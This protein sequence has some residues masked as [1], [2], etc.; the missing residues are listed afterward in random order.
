[1]LKLSYPLLQKNY[2][3][4]TDF[5]Q[6]NLQR[7]FQNQELKFNFSKNKY[8]FNFN[9]FKQDLRFLQTNLYESLI[10]Y[11]EC[12]EILL[13]SLL[14][15]RNME[16][17]K[18]G[19]SWLKE[20]YLCDKQSAL[21]IAIR[22]AQEYFNACSSYFDSDM[23]FARECLNL[24]Q[25]MMIENSSEDD[26]IKTDLFEALKY[27]YDL[28]NAIRLICDEFDFNILPVQV[29]VG[30]EQQRMQI[31]KDIIIKKENSYKNYAKLIELGDYLHIKDKNQIL[32][33]VTHNSLERN[34]LLILK[35]M[36]T[37]MIKSNY[38]QAWKCV[39]KLS[40]NL[41]QSLFEHHKIYSEKSIY[42]SISKHKFNTNNS[43]SGILSSRDKIIKSLHEIENLLSFVLA[44]CDLDMVQ[45]VLY[46]KLNIEKARMNLEL[47]TVDKEELYSKISHNISDILAFETIKCDFFMNE[48]K[49][50]SL[51][52]SNLMK[53]KTNQVNLVLQRL[54]NSAND[55]HELINYLKLLSNLD[56]SLVFSYLL[57]IDDDSLIP[58]FDGID[59]SPNLSNKTY[60]FL[61]HTTSLD[62]IN[63]SK[64]DE[65]RD[66]ES[67]SRS[68]LYDLNF[69]SLVRYLEQNGDLNTDDSQRMCE[70]FSR[71]NRAFIE[72]NQN[73]ELD[74]LD[75]GIDLKRFERDQQ[76]KHETI[77]GLCMDVKTFK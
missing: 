29:R 58:L 6:P 2:F 60:E 10:S 76:Y 53:T 40:F 65:I 73:I 31:I 47:E 30:N 56:S 51:Y 44:N 62:L 4:K 66:L 24:I 41:C 54:R 67:S 49:S 9:F 1:M 13:N 55:K 77:L 26:R 68:F 17:I 35:E 28:I 27:E 33:Q 12:T 25:E 16:N 69:K 32:L 70:F 18:L 21:N 72:H 36:C 59:L 61:L 50:L 71:I 34:N 11:Q 52:D 38:T 63:N 14:S 39:H 5:K 57:E 15:S 23:E 64:S 75:L 46:Q 19:S 43:L 7:K 42:L 37:R 22:A 8:H 48:E 3:I 20:I 45:E 74:K